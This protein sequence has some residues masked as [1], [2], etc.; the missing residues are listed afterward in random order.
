MM[1]FTVIALKTKLK[2]ANQDKI[3]LAKK[4]KQW[5]WIELQGNDIKVES[6]V[7]PLSGRICLQ[8]T[9]THQL[10]LIYHQLLALWCLSLIHIQSPAEFLIP[11]EVS[12]SGGKQS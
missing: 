6:E 9:K 2:K 8:I 12:Q 1:K 7:L 5:N 3:K 4:P 11:V 10:F